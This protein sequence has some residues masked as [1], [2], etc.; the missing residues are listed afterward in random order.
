MPDDIPADS[1]GADPT[2]GLDAPTPRHRARRDAQ[3]ERVVRQRR[4]VALGGLGALAALA[5][6][7]GAITG[8][9]GGQDTPAAEQGEELAELPGG[10]RS[11]FPERRVVGFYGAPQDEELG[12]LGIGTPAEAAKRLERQARPYATKARPVLPA[13]ELLAVVAAA[14][15]GDDGLYRTR[16]GDDVIA[17]YL[18]AARREDAILL[19]DIQPG[20]ADFL[21]EAKALRR[22]LEEPDVGLAL[23]PE[24]RMAEG[25]VP[26]QTIG[27]VDAGEVNEVSAWLAQIV[28]RERLPEKLFL[29]HRFTEDMIVEPETLQRHRGIA[30]TLNVDGFGT[31]EQ[32]LAKY[33]DLVPRTSNAGFKLFYRE[34]EGLMSPREVL[35]LRPEPDFVVYE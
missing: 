21:T 27:S 30:L 12:E 4:R 7:V 1:A 16:Q 14:A 34:D 8:A 23:D 29:V 33:R 3:H 22:W 26:G 32:K 13:F 6:L 18:E 11:L 20:Q 10:G 35:A 5:F 25:Q 24:W 15:P 9:G 28:R 19:L 31:K 2:A 17:K